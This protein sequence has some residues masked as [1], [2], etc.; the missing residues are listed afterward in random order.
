MRDLKVFSKLRDPGFLAQQLSWAGSGLSVCFTLRRDFLNFADIRPLT[1]SLTSVWAEGIRP[2]IF[3]ITEP[4]IQTPSM[5]LFTQS[6][7]PAWRV[8]RHRHCP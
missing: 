1:T 8:V 4:Q 3:F 5:H 2:D 6:E 7:V